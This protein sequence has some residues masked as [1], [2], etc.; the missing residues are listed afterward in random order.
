MS[1]SPVGKCIYC[2]TAEWE[3]GSGR[4][5]GDEH[6]IP[7]SIGG[8]LLLPQ[9]SCKRCERL[10]C[11][12]ET[13]AL[14]N[15]LQGPRRYLGLKGRT[16]AHKQRRKLPLFVPGAEEKVM[17]NVEDY[18]STLYLPRLGN[19]PILQPLVSQAEVP[20]PGW[21]FQWFNYREGVLRSKYGVERW[22]AVAIDLPIFCRMLA[23]IGHAY[24]AANIGLDGFVPFLC[25]ALTDPESITTP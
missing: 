9:A 5:L 2:G 21:F 8:N 12:A 4:K 23:K 25:D 11:Q 20:Q 10:T 15:H 6:I 18:P 14:D 16:P 24:A 7:L 1:Y 3:S 13:I 19:P 17:V 22:A